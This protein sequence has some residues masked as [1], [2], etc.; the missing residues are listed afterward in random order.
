MQPQETLPQSGFKRYAGLF[1]GLAARMRDRPQLVTRARALRVFGCWLFDLP[2][3]FFALFGFSCF[4]TVFWSR[5][6]SGGRCGVASET[7]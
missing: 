5:K 7:V 6:L 2:Y 3:L 1:A 4:F